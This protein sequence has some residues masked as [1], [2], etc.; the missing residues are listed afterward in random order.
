MR[1]KAGSTI[2]V[3]F[4]FPLPFGLPLGMSLPFKT[5][6]MRSRICRERCQQHKINA[7]TNIKE[8]QMWRSIKECSQQFKWNIDRGKW[9]K[10][11]IVISGNVLLAENG[12]VKN[13]CVQPVCKLANIEKKYCNMFLKNHDSKAPSGAKCKEERSNHKGE[14]D[15][16]KTS[17]K[18]WACRS[19]KK[20]SEGSH[21]GR[22]HTVSP[23]C[24]HSPAACASSDNV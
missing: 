15:A 19:H 20:H 6:I 23:H 10:Q 8:L 13:A 1:I 18:G 12:S 14:K 21:K 4:P 16:K 9:T 17:S 7:I 22:M 3:I 24:H 2:H 5:C 11:S